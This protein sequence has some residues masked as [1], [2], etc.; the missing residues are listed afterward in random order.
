[1]KS[2]NPHLSA[3]NR[4]FKPCSCPSVSLLPTP[5]LYPSPPTHP[6]SRFSDVNS[7]RPTNGTILPEV[8]LKPRRTKLKGVKENRAPTSS[9]SFPQ[10]PPVHSHRKSRNPSKSPILVPV[11]LSE[12]R[13]KGK[14]DL[15]KGSFSHK[16]AILASNSHSEDCYSTPIVRLNIR[17]LA[18][19]PEAR[20]ARG[21]RSS[22][23]GLTARSRRF[24]QLSR[25]YRLDRK[26]LQR[27]VTAISYTSISLIKHQYRRYATPE[28]LPSADFMS[29][30][31]GVTR[32]SD[33]SE[34]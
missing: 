14:A 8:P 30:L 23:P 17:S 12:I 25:H 26:S 1:M 15:R 2:V 33:Y 24:Q 18:T 11:T 28:R 34:W 9:H 16:Q 29:E 20:T 27:E 13:E 22:S 21:P 10:E 7:Y 32:I 31:E 6:R 4:I 19:E 5:P 3:R